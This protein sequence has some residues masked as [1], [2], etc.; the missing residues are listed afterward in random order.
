MPGKSGSQREALEAEVA[1]RISIQASKSAASIFQSW[2]NP[3]ERRVV[4]LKGCKDFCLTAK[5]RI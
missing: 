3:A 5:A 2:L 4:S 1:L